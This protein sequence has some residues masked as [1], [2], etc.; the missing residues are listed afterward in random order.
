VPGHLPAGHGERR[1]RPAIG[2]SGGWWLVAVNT[3]A[4][5]RVT[6]I[7]ATRSTPNAATRSTPGAAAHQMRAHHLDLPLF[8]SK[9]DHRNMVILRECGD[10]PP[11]PTPIQSKVAGNGIRNPRRTIRSDTTYPD[12]QFR[13]VAVQVD[14]VQTL[15]VQ[16]Q[17]PVQNVRDRHD[18]R[19]QGLAQDHQPRATTSTRVPPPS[20]S[21]SPRRTL[22]TA[23]AHAVAPRASTSTHPP[24]PSPARPATHLGGPKRSLMEFWPFCQDFDLIV[25]SG[26]LARLHSPP[27][28]E[29]AGD[30][31]QQSRIWRESAHRR[32]AAHNRASNPPA[33]VPTRRV[34]EFADSPRDPGGGREDQF[35]SLL[36]AHNLEL[37][38]TAFHVNHRRQTG[39]C[40]PVGLTMRSAPAHCLAPTV[41]VASSRRPAPTNGSVPHRAEPLCHIMLEGT[42][43][44]AKL[45]ERQHHPLICITWP[46]AN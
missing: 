13:H 24:Q 20:H 31:K 37:L 27:S 17:V 15:Q 7:A 18:P 5:S 8:P 21:V 29:S 34:A 3:L 19:H 30:S 44:R 38:R 9:P 11:G 10:H 4:Y 6:S 45:A 42:R 46:S 23:T 33:H 41:D 22:E 28:C 39:I 16:D 43:R 14:P 40:R 35:I 2:H 36:S 12:L 32:P 26:A 1:P 25:N